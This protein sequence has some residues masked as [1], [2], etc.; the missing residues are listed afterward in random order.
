MIENA[1]IAKRVASKSTSGRRT[2]ILRPVVCLPQRR[3]PPS[4]LSIAT[5]TAVTSILS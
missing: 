2:D 5:G 1:A 4:Q 3:K